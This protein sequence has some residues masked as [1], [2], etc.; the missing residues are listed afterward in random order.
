M[1]GSPKQVEWAKDIRKAFF[2]DCEIEIES[3]NEDPST[4]PLVKQFFYFI[5][6][7]PATFWID[8]RFTKPQ[9]LI[10]TLWSMFEQETTISLGS[11]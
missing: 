9:E 11:V 3:M 6:D 4:K 2:E 8:S 1:K 7:Q 5:N 10:D